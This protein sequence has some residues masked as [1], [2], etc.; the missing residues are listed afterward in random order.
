MLTNNL[1]AHVSKYR[2]VINRAVKRVL[3]RSQFVMGPE[4]DGFERS[5]ASYVGA[6]RCIGVA[7]GTDAL[8]IS[9]RALNICNEDKIATVANAGMYST[10]AILAVNAVPIFMDVDLDTHSISVDEVKLAIEADAKIVVVTHLYGQANLHIAEIA[11][12][13]R[14]SG[15]ALI[16]DCAQSHGAMINGK[17]VGTFGD[18]GCFSFYPTKNL[19]ALGDAGAIVCSNDMLAERLC[20]LRQYGWSRKYCV[21][22][23]GAQNSRLDEIQAAILSALLPYLDEWNVRRRYIASRYSCEIK[24]PAVTTAPVRDADYVA[25]LY[26]LRSIYRDELREH[27]RKKNI[28]TDIHYPIPDYRQPI[29]EKACKNF[30]L[31]NTDQLSKE[32][33]TIPCYPEMTDDDVRIVIDA[34]NS[35]PESF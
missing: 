20:G 2:K 23:A 1:H 9:F 14:A 13:C 34:V 16:E 30:R 27:L 19:G 11:A 26:V 31:P 6:T 17:K 3:D 21:E 29:L 8:T 12:V 33:L 4:V 28:G 32:I 5:F 7:N 35:F 15:V 10:T 25:H 22:L 18:V 24:H